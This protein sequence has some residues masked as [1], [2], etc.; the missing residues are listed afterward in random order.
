M[1]K[2]VL[3]L[4]AVLAIATGAQAR[5]YVYGDNEMIMESEGY[6][7]FASD[8]IID[9]V[10]RMDKAGNAAGYCSGVEEN[11]TKNLGDINSLRS[12][13][14]L[15]P[16]ASDAKISYSASCSAFYSLVD[17]L[18]TADDI[19]RL[20]LLFADS[21][22]DDYAVKTLKEK[23]PGED[24]SVLIEMKRMAVVSNY[25]EYFTKNRDWRLTDYTFLSQAFKSRKGKPL[26]P[27]YGNF[28]AALMTGDAERAY[29]IVKAVDLDNLGSRF[30][31]PGVSD[32]IKGKGPAARGL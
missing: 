2:V 29:R 20:W 24:A 8:R 15:P 26:S 32:D 21:A 9:T 5:N 30:S 17:R 10:G 12:D 23:G 4:M 28:V 14:R 27:A 16:I 22:T 25:I 11:T 6:K 1:N 13:S 7:L 31:A 18:K 3:I 19:R